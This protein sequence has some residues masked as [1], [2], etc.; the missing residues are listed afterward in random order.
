MLSQ[1]YRKALRVD[2]N[3]LLVPKQRKE[4]WDLRFVTTYN[5]QWAE[6]R[7]LLAK[8]RHIVSS[9][10]RLQPLI[11]NAPL[12][13]ARRAPNLADQLTRRHFSRP[14]VSIGRGSRLVESFPC[15]NCNVCQFMEPTKHF[16]NLSNDTP[17]VLRGYV[18]CKTKCVIYG[19]QCPCSLLYIGQTTQQRKQPVQ[20]H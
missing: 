15:W 3:T 8:N 6:I 19:L 16:I 13:T 20:K 12:L 9:D 10:S 1:A 14:Q 7:G 17:T 4:S 18:N 11:P 5:N 2:R